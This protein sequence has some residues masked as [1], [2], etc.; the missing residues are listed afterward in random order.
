MIIGAGPG[1]YR[2]AFMA[3][4]LGMDVTMVD[5]EENPGGVCLYRGCIPTKA[6]LS[7]VKIK[8]TALDALEMGIHFGEPKIKREEIVSWKQDVVNKL[9][10][11]L[12]QLTRARKINY[13]RGYA[14]FLDQSSLEYKDLDGKKQG[15]NF[16]KA[17]IA[18]GV[19]GN[20][21]PNA[22]FDGKQI[23]GATAALEIRDIPGS[24]LIVGGGYIGL[25]M[26][27]IYHNL[28][29]KVTIV[30]LTDNFLPGMDRDL[31]KEYRKKGDDLF[32]AILFETSLEKAEKGK[33]G[34]KAT[35]KTK[36]GKKLIK[37]F[38]KVLVAIGERPDH[39]KLGL[40]NT[41]VE[42]DD[43]GFIRVDR[44]QKTSVENIF[45]IGD[46]T[47]GPL[48]AHKAMYEG[49]VAAEV[50]AGKATVFD[51]RA[52]PSVIYTDPEIAVCG[53]TESAA[54]KSG[55]K[56]DLARFRWSASGRAATMNQSLGF[57]K[58]LV[59]P[60]NGRILGGAIVGS[61]A[62]EL[63]AEIAL[64]IEM[65]ANVTDLSLTVHPHPTLSE[66]IMDAAEWQ[67]GHP[68][69]IMRKTRK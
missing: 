23:I 6:L 14:R 50:A 68:V 46:V 62:A 30:E 54:R 45:A 48:L 44:Q 63:I 56:Y 65:G 20:E 4:D 33:D 41:G 25:E 27:T 5:P 69:H 60:E 58:L 47:G 31:V 36:D 15:I 13:L 17:I 59:D 28:G 39:S 43:N 2:A 38:D 3:A 35:M 55:R 32:H 16:E 64:A 1:G 67:L 10:G 26:A 42:T 34:V 18:T 24:L 12:G 61:D 57:T 11:G 22:R 8:K 53:L 19:Q 9:T 21:L 29:S 51:V 37:T 66:T 40:E 7:L 52:M 49:A